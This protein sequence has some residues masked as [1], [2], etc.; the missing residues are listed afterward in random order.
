MWFIAA[1]S[2]QVSGPLKP[3]RDFSAKADMK[4]GQD[5]KKELSKKED[6]QNGKQQ[7]SSKFRFDFIAKTIPGR[8]TFIRGGLRHK[9]FRRQEF[10]GK[11]DLFGIFRLGSIREDT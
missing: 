10:Q 1:R 9:I 5:D 4:I 3:C 2:G 8:V 7:E 11:F 6:M